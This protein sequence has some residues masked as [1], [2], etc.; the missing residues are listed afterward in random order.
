MRG[1]GPAHDPA[2]PSVQHD[3]QVEE[4]GPG[5]DVRDVGHPELIGAIGREVSLHQVGRR[6]GVLVA[7]R[8]LRA[9]SVSARPLD[10]LLLHESADTLLSDLFACF[11]QIG[12]DPGPAVDLPVVVKHLSDL[13]DPLGISPRTIRRPAAQPSVVAAGGES[14]HAAH[15]LDGEIG[16]MG[17][18]ELESRSGIELLSR[19]DQAAAFPRMSRSIRSCRTSRFNWH[20]SC[21]SSVVSPSLRT[22]SSRSACLTQVRIAPAEGSNSRASSSGLRPDRTTRRSAA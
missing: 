10:P 22:P 12:E 7:L 20:N 9:T 16:L 17:V 6:P 8:G 2:A 18:H 14:Q 3:R 1:H 13:H 4:A 21:R 5:G 15:P 11:L 19:A